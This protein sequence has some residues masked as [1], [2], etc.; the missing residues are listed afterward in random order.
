MEEG[1][2]GKPTGVFGELAAF[3]DLPCFVTY[4][5]VAETLEAQALVHML[6]NWY[7]CFSI[8]VQCFFCFEV[9]KKHMRPG[10]L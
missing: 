5:V 3:K 10:L 1:R 8:F 6:L 9:L 7:Y 2:K 4:T